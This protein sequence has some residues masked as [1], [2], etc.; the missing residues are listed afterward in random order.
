ME[1]AEI[2]AT[3]RASVIRLRIAYG[4]DQRIRKRI[5]INSAGAQPKPWG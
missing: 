1:T 2:G 5:Q 4:L 3:Q